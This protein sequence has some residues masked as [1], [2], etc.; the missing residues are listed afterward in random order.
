MCG[1]YLLKVFDFE[2]LVLSNKNLICVDDSKDASS[3]R[4]P[5]EGIG[6]SLCDKFIVIT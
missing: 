6:E 4:I 3:Y 2:R 1:F 5:E